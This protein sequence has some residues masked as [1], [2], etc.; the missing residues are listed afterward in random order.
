[1][2][3]KYAALLMVLVIA[4]MLPAC[5]S[6][7]D[8]VADP[9]AVSEE[10][11]ED[12]AEEFTPAATPFEAMAGMTLDEALPVFESLEYDVTYYFN[13]TNISESIPDT[14]SDYSIE[15]AELGDEKNTLDVELKLLDKEAEQDEE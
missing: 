8:D 9:E 7:G 13:G 11:V 2:K 4:L 15:S 12:E 10:Q 5:G 1:M 14:S 6:K 3:K